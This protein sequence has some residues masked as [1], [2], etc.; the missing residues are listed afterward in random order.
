M[1]YQ[2]N[3]IKLITRPVSQANQRPGSES[4][5][6]ILLTYLLIRGIVIARKIEQANTTVNSRVQF[7]KFWC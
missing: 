7:T 6:Q 2:S 4:E 5:A 3:Q 1:P